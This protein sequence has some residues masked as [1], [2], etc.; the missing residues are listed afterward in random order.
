MGAQL[1]VDGRVS[2]SSVIRWTP[3]FCIHSQTFEALFY[4]EQTTSL[5][6]I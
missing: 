3:L 2:A 4:F 6:M 5:G 1:Y